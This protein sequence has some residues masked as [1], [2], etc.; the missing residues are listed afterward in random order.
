MCFLEQAPYVS[1]RFRLNI[2]PTLV[3]A[4]QL[5][6]LVVQ[7][8]LS[9]M[10][11]IQEPLHY[12]IDSP[13]YKCQSQVTQGVVGQTLLEGANHRDKQSSNQITAVRNCPHSNMRRDNLF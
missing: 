6:S 1:L 5:L 11:N 2:T 10:L 4:V 13:I 7:I 9:Q 3:F 12:L 8:F